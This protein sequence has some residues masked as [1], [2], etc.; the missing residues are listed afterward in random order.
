MLSLYNAAHSGCVTGDGA[1][2]RDM[3]M[4]TE[5]GHSCLPWDNMTSQDAN[6]MLYPD[7]GKDQRRY[8]GWN[9]VTNTNAIGN[10]SK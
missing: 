8:K 2:Y 5:S 7:A 10:Y 9:V 4:Y 6:P 1:D 3:A